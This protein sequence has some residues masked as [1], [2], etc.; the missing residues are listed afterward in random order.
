[1]RQRKIK[2]LGNKIA[3]F[4]DLIVSEPEKKRGLWR[5]VFNAKLGS[6]HIVS[7]DSK[8]FAEIGSGKGR[9]IIKTAINNPENLY[10]GI[11]GHE[12]V[13]YRSLQKACAGSDV[14]KFDIAE[15]ALKSGLKNAPKNLRFVMEYITDAEI[16]FAPGELN[17]IFLNFCDPWPKARQEKRRLTSPAK[18]RSYLDVLI[19]DGFIRFKTDN[20]ALYRYSYNAINETSG[21]DITAYVEDMHKSS[22]NAE[23]IKT[24][25]E[26]KFVNLHRKIYYIEARKL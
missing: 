19:T 22:F 14:S 11:E 20:E 16:L 4:S 3:V 25:Y 26:Q 18:L 1:M 2:D 21:L 23:N 8:L 17:G 12:S 24:E 6:Q 7:S 10:L 5:E 9:F 15:L 13:F